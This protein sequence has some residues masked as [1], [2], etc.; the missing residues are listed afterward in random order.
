M[1]RAFSLQPLLELMQTRRDEASRRLGQL[2]ALE[3]NE[4]ARL[5]MLEQYRAEYAGKLNAACADGVT[6]EQLRNHQAF[7]ARIDDAIAQQTQ[8]LTQSRQRTDQGRQ[9]WQNQDRK[10]KAID[11]L[12]TRHQANERLRENKQEQKLLD[13][14]SLRRH[15]ASAPDDE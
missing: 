8:A 6:L 4:Q 5:S 10:L 14:Y 2:L 9:H 11:T 15:R 12:S 13:E 3:R 1:A 7:L